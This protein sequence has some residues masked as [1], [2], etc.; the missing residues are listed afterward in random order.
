MERKSS[1]N[2][3]YPTT[4]RYR[5]QTQSGQSGV[6]RRQSDAYDGWY[7]GSGYG[8]Y[9]AEPGGGWSDADGYYAA[10]GRSTTSVRRAGNTGYDRSGRSA[11]DWDDNY[12]DGYVSDRPGSTSG[13][14]MTSRKNEYE[15]GYWPERDNAGSVRR[16][17]GNTASGKS[18]A[19]SRSTSGNTASGRST[20]GSRSTSGNTPSGKTASGSRDSSRS[21][22]NPAGNSRRSASGNRPASSSTSKGKNTKN[23]QKKSGRGG[24]KGGILF[25][26]VLAVICAAGLFF[27]RSK[28]DSSKNGGFLQNLRSG[29]LFSGKSSQ[30][31]QISVS[32]DSL[33]SPYAIMIDAETGE[34][35]ASKSG[36]EIIY[37]ASMAKIMTVLTAIEHIDNL[38]QTITMSYDY[39]D[40]LYEQ[41]ASR[42]GFEP[43]EEAKIRELLY[44]ALL[45]S[46]AECCM[47]LSIQ[48]A[49]S[50][51]AFADL[52]NQ[53]AQELGL[54]Q[55]HFV[56]CTGLHSENQYSTPHEIAKIL[57]E[58]LKNK[59]F[60]EVF[61]THSYSV[62]PSNVHPDGF[63]FWSSMFKN[64]Q[65]E[66]VIGGEILG[67][68]TGYTG[69][70]GFCLASMAEIH[71]REYIQ[72]TAGWAA[73]PRV[74]QYHINDAFLGYNIVGRAISELNER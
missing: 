35:I 34:V 74:N 37:P 61:T 59:T 32:L 23:R 69:E 43:G 50:E 17:E 33:D 40:A 73:N 20:S 67:G 48:A 26:L 64:M 22:K 38:D 14:R 7:D 9:E 25:L 13:R 10:A 41:D 54:T 72:V 47:E 55:T 51:S 52:M 68:K 44:G 63:T 39:Y 56:N 28:E 4:E 58:A 66:N 24:L 27:L 62:A 8:R 36:D 29:S 3:R 60:R 70:A 42:A 6:R 53:K 71:G 21:A 19:R 12:A 15:D 2:G 18:T 30:I 11:Y 1:G 65:A 46:G 49:G 57:R 5:S 45:P 16:S 31:P